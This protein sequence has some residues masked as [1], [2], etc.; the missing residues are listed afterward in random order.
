MKTIGTAT[1][2]AI[3]VF[4]C[5]LF[6]TP[7]F[8]CYNWN[9]FP[10]QGEEHPLYH[11]GTVANGTV[12]GGVYYDAGHG[13]TGEGPPLSEDPYIPNPYI[14]TFSVPDYDK[15]LF[16]RLYVLHLWGG[17]ANYHGWVNTSFND[18]SLGNITLLGD[19]DVGSECEQQV[20]STS[21]GVYVVRYNVTSLV[22]TGTNTASADTGKLK[23]SFD[24]RVNA[25]GLIV[26]YEKEGMSKTRY[27][28]VQGHEALTYAT[29]GHPARD[30]GYAY[31]N[32]T[33]DPNE[34]ESAVFYSVYTA[35]DTG[36]TDTLWFNDKLLCEGCTNYEQGPYF[37]FKKFEV[38]NDTVN[39][40]TT[41]GNY[42]RY[43]RDGD[44]YVHWMNA[45]L[46]LSK[47]SKPNL[48]VE[49]IEE[50]VLPYYNY[51]LAVVANHTYKVNATVKNIGTGAANE[52]QVTLHADTALIGTLPVPSLDAGS[53]KEV[54]FSWTP[55]ASG[56][57]TLKVT[58]DATNQINES[59]EK[60]NNRSKDTDVLPEVEADLAI[61]PKDIQFLPAFAWHAAN[62]KTTIQVNVANNGTKDAKK[63][64]V[65]LFVDA[66]ERDKT[67]L[68]VVAKAVKVTSF[69][70]DAP[71]GGPYTVKVV[72]DA[73]SEVHESNESNNE[74]ARLLKVIEIR[75]RS[76]HHY[77]DTSI[78]NAIESNWTDVEMFDV[79]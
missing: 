67:R 69:V 76:T 79:T 77:G 44:Q 28:V 21:C 23:G 7:A 37:D 1:A 18:H 50:P 61:T 45:V 46:V 75:V 42:A 56:T 55:S 59:D 53:S 20:W 8:A 3:A 22:T 40:L 47:E 6:C 49:K 29:S 33:I 12:I 9:G 43:W 68:S 57:C 26:V 16:A 74:A 35:G 36:D 30:Y 71:K 66:M 65:R 34:W 19:D 24:G 31:F 41:S 48:I 78:Y 27:W 52:S 73:N 5:L 14:Q 70:Y 39:H 54:R 13:L 25:I 15:V 11:N 60:N 63:F 2:I 64:D 17:T 58:A 62:N 51:T 10:M 32:G 38:K 4:A 72:L